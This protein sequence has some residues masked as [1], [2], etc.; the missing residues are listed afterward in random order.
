[1]GVP[2][3]PITFPASCVRAILGGRKSQARFI[4][5]TVQEAGTPRPERCPYGV[6]GTLLW[7]REHWN[8]HPPLEEPDGTLV[9]PYEVQ[10]VYRADVPRGE[11]GR[12][13]SR[14]WLHPEVMPRWASRIALRLTTVEVERLQEISDDDLQREGRMWRE[15]AP[16]GPNETELAGFARWWDS[17][18]SRPETLWRANPLVWVM[19]FA[20]LL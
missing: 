5:D 11:R 12:M 18:H 17:V 20:V 4:V 1:M 14:L 2:E 13:P 10:I 8:T 15:H 6:R 16:L 19:S 7:V 3:R 9:P